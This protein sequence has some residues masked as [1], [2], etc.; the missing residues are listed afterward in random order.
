MTGIYSTSHSRSCG[1]WVA[2][3]VQQL[4]CVAALLVNGNV[5]MAAS[6]PRSLGLFDDTLYV[7]AGEQG[8]L[9]DLQQTLLEWLYANADHYG[10]VR[11]E[12]LIAVVG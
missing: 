2:I 10:R 8:Y 9:A 3:S 11:V 12:K 4:E 5:T 1:A 7:V 6:V